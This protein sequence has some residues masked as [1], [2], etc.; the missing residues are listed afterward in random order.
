MPLVK[1][2]RECKCFQ[3]SD[4]K[5]VQEFDTIDEA[6]EVS[7]RMCQEM[8]ETFCGKHH[9]RAVYDGENMIIKVEMN[10]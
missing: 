7:N 10:G 5:A 9:F 1:M 3:E 6:L 8:N 4:Y 2:Q